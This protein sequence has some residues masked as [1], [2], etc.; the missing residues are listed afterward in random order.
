MGQGTAM[1]AHLPSHMVYINSSDCLKKMM[2][3]EGTLSLYKGITAPMIGNMGMLGIH[4]PVFAKTMHLLGDESHD[5]LNIW[6]SLVS[7]GMAGMAGSF[8]STPVELIRTK[9]QL[10]TKS[11]TSTVT[12]SFS[13]SSKNN[14][15]YRGSFDCARRL[16]SEHG[17]RGVYRGFGSTML[18][19]TQGYAFFFL[20]Y[21]TMIHAI[22]EL[23]YDGQKKRSEMACWD[24]AAA[25]SFAGMSLWAS[26]YPIDTIKSKMQADNLRDPLYKSTLD[27]YRKTMILEGNAGMWRGFSAALYRALPV[28]AAVFLA[29]DAA[30]DFTAK[31]HVH[32]AEDDD[33]AAVEGKLGFFSQNAATP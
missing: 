24:I 10:Q 4:F 7:G 1:A 12:K 15:N 8:V 28:N 20:A 30:K 17:I 2:R 31:Y 14:S 23:R 5:R 21:E 19:D 16:I 33:I 25:G 13:D 3:H 32:T 11:G 18:R 29:V 22:L 27:C 26:M 9:L 6:K